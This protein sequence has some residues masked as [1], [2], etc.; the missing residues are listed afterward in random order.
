[1]GGVEVLQALGMKIIS[2]S[3]AL[4]IGEFQFGKI[5]IQVLDLS[6]HC[7]PTASYWI[8]GFKKSLWVVGDAIFAG[9]MG[10]CKSPENFTMA[11]ATLRKGFEQLDDDCLILPGHGPM[12]S[13]GLEKASNPFRKHFA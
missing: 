8:T 2:E 6:G 12:T 1:V 3:E 5:R 7:V 4:Q 9:S 13:V 10:G 11:A